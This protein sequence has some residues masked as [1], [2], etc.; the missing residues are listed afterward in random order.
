MRTAVVDLF[1]G[2]GGLTCGLKKAGLRVVAGID[3]DSTCKY[4]YET[5]NHAKFIEHD[6]STYPAA[7]LLRY[8]DGSDIKILVGCAPCQTFS[9]QAN[10]Y[11]KRIDQETDFRWNLLKSF[12]RCV[13]EVE[14]DIVSMENVPALQKFQVFKDFKDA[15][16]RMGYKVSHKVVACAKYGLPQN[17]RRLVL[18]ASKLGDIKLLPESD[19]RFQNHRTVR[20]VIGNLPALKHGA[21]NKEDPLH[22]CAGLSEINFERMKQSKPGG[23]WHDWDVSLLPRCYKKASGQSFTSVYGRMVWDE[24]SPTITTQ[25]YSFGTGRYG[26]PSQNRALSL[27]EGAL[28]QTFPE[29]Y[30]FFENEDQLSICT[31]SRHIGNAVPVDLGWIIGLSIKEHLKSIY[32][33]RSKNDKKSCVFA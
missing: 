4:A 6:I 14:P 24:P 20:S 3:N 18:L 5:N 17:R 9:T 29:D 7:E 13:R 28:L 8:Y 27:R 1:C 19:P 11:R 31:I 22:R 33:G 10:K 12:E 23:T 21:R 2:I 30:K 26:H 32:C 15:L 16:E 25:F